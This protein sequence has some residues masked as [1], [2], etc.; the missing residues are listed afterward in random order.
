[1][2]EP[3]A[4][5]STT[6]DMLENDETTSAS[7]EEPTVT[8]VETQPGAPIEVVVPLFHDEMAVRTPAPRRLSIPG[9]RVSLSQVP[10][11]EPPPRLMLAEATVMPP[12]RVKWANTWSSAR[13]VSVPDD[14]TQGAGFG[15]QSLAALK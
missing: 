15:E 3:G 6:F 2:D 7:V 4:S 5:T 9:L 8:A 10:V 14:R 13:T 1:M 12:L 11:C